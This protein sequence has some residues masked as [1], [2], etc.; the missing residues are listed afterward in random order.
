MRAKCNRDCER[1]AYPDCI[2]DGELDNSISCA[3]WYDRNKEKKREY[4][5]EYARR[6]RAEK[7]K[8]VSEEVEEVKR[9]VVCGCILTDKRAKKCCSYECRLEYRN[10]YLRQYQANNKAHLNEYQKEYKR[11]E[12]AKQ[13]Y[14]GYINYRKLFSKPVYE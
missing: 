11:K 10:R 2:N 1:C 9:C 14:V 8:C 13:D 5:R 4:Q 7:K 12:R 6:K 3:N